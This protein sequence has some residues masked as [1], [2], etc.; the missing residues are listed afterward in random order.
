MGRRGNWKGPAGEM[1]GGASGV[2]DGVTDAE[3]LGGVQ[4]KPGAQRSCHFSW[5]NQHI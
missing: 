3:G 2:T 4:G 1:G 5:L